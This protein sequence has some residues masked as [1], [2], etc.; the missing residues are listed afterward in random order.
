VTPSPIIGRLF[1]GAL[2]AL[3]GIVAMALLAAVWR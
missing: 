2:L 1:L 3:L